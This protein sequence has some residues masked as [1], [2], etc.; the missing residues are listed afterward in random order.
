[1]GFFVPNP[2][3]WLKPINDLAYV[4]ECAANDHTAEL[5]RELST[6]IDRIRSKESGYDLPVIQE[7]LPRLETARDCY[8]G[9]D[10]ELSSHDATHAASR[11]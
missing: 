7:A 9:G 4:V 1:M 11:R 3:D 5:Q 10:E 6:L 2:P 8:H